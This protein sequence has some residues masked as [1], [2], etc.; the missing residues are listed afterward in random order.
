MFLWLIRQLLSIRQVIAGRNHPHQLAW[1][2]ALGVLVG[3]V[4]H[5]NLLAVALIA[6]V[7]AL[8]INHAMATLTG[9]A[10]AFSATALDP[11]THLIGRYVLTHPEL[12]TAWA[13]A[14]QLPL[15]PWTDI[16]NTVVMGSLLLGLGAV[17]PTYAA[18]YPLFRYLAPP[19]TPPES[20][21]PVDPV[22]SAAVALPVL[23]DRSPRVV[24]PPAPVPPSLP[25]TSEAAEPHAGE[26]E[27]GQVG[28]R[29]V[30]TQI[31]VIRLK[32][33]GRQAAG[34]VQQ[35]AD[36]PPTEPSDP[37][38]MNQ[39]LSYLLRRLRDSQQGKAA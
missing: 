11:Y 7:L 16:N 28:L 19:A 36:A 39:A 34:D 37:A 22:A 32:D 2:L 14:W 15:V 30:E 10:V 6:G 23:D 8:R 29:M 31:D 25:S 1:G 35:A 33:F 21:T 18:S 38:Q 9:V 24:A 4:P 27:L 5:G 20:P 17:L 13:Q 3:V 12:Q 26:A